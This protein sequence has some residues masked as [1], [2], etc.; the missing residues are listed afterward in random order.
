MEVGSVPDGHG[1][2]PVLV[3]SLPPS[4]ADS[5]VADGRVMAVEN[6]SGAH[7]DR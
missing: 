2:G 4:N 1:V 7:R 6:R 5:F 3:R